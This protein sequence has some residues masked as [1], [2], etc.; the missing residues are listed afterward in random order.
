MYSVNNLIEFTYSLMKSIL[1]TF[2]KMNHIY[3][4]SNMNMNIMN[5]NMI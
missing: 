3:Y 4:E 1:F 2:I 5:Q